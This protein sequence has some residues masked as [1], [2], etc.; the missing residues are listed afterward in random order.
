MASNQERKKKKHTHTRSLKML[1]LFPVWEEESE[2]SF[3]TERG[4]HCLF[5]CLTAHVIEA[6]GTSRLASTEKRH[7]CLSKRLRQ[8]TRLIR[9]DRSVT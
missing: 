4:V 5:P 8:P 3:Q 2:E 1:L 7:W 6:L 9:E